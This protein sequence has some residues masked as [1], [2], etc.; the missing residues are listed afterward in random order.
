MLQIGS[1]MFRN[2]HLEGRKNPALM[3]GRG[4]FDPRFLITLRKH[5]T[6]PKRQVFVVPIGPKTHAQLSHSNNADNTVLPW[7]R[8]KSL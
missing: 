4:L 6:W 1:S 8:G 3:E 5:V 7:Q 2:D